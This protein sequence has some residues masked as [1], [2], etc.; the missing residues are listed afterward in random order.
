[1]EK[2]TLK[3]VTGKV[4]I[5][6]V[7]SVVIL[8]EN[9][10]F[11]NRVDVSNINAEGI[12]TKLN[13]ENTSLCALQIAA[14]YLAIK[15]E[16]FIHSEQVNHRYSSYYF[17]H[18]IE[19]NKSYQMYLAQAGSIA[20]YCSNGNFITAMLLHDFTMKPIKGSMNALFNV[21]H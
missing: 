15:D 11:L 2:A 13:T 5:E 7:E 9:D 17:K 4:T 18:L 10:T 19:A 12:K 8:T 16:D 1:M 14:A 3:T 21:K 20:A 6:L